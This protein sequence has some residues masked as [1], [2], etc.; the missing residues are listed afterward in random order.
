M[1]SGDISFL[2]FRGWSFN[3]FLQNGC[4]KI[5]RALLGK[6]ALWLLALL[7]IEIL[8]IL[9]RITVTIFATNGKQQAHNKQSAES[10]S[11]EKIEGSIHFPFNAPAPIE[12][13]AFH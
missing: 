10:Q 6:E 12:S 4:H 9:A 13:M 1:A 11:L 7:F 3:L 8:W 2:G 5:L